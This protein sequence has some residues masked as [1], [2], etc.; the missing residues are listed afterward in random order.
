MQGTTGVGAILKRARMALGVSL[1]EA[2]RDTRIRP[3]VLAGL[4]EERFGRFRG[5][6]HVRGLI[7]T[8]ARYLGL[9]AD[10][11]VDA[12]QRHAPETDETPPPLE[13]TVIVPGRDGHRLARTAAV[14][15]LALAAGLGFLSARARSPEPADL[16]G[17]SPAPT[18]VASSRGLLLAVTAQRDLGIEVTLDDGE[19]RRYALVTGESRSFDADARIVL[20]LDEGASATVVVNGVDLGSPGAA[21][22]P[23]TYTFVPGDALLSPTPT[24]SEGAP[25]S[26]GPSVSADPS[27]SPL[28]PS[29]SA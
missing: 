16:D 25:S 26:A 24:P 4:E 2:A 12:F 17:A 29:P 13:E 6:V 28:P 15:V 19:M 3:E 27:G 7:R 20:S 11:L 1:D 18:A 22:V 5:A 14:V 8:Y 23:W 9:P 10:R 21:G